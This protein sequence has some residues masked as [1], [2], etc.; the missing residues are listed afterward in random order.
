MSADLIHPGH[1][2]ILKK[3]SEL[4]EVVVGVLTDS[5]I[6]SY[7][8]LPYMN[9]DQR[10]EIISNL[11]SVHKVIP[12]DTLDYSNNLNELKPDFVVHGD[13]W[14]DGIQQETRQNVINTIAKWGGELIEVPYTKSV[15]STALNQA[16][17]EI[18]TT[19][20]IRLASLRRLLTAKPFNTFF[21]IFIMP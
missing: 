7:K 12:Q 6:A 17:R 16:V 18:G 20:Q 8:R 10:S 13:D 1:I 19:P 4:G 15:S 14:K 5:A 11:K 2:N 9:Y 21:L 3:A